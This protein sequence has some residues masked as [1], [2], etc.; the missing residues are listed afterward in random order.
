MVKSSCFVLFSRRKLGH[1]TTFLRKL[2]QMPCSIAAN[3]DPFNE[4]QFLYTSI[5]PLYLCYVSEES[6]FKPPRYKDFKSNTPTKIL[7]YEYIHV[8]VSPATLTSFVAPQGAYVGVASSLAM[9]VW[10]FTGA[11]LYPPSDLRGPVSISDC[12]S[13]VF[14]RTQ[15]SLHNDTGMRHSNIHLHV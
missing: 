5:V 8:H 10:L 4:K 13:D 7:P 2:I 12:P 14:N 9:T 15:A 3:R 1:K 6:A 11:Q